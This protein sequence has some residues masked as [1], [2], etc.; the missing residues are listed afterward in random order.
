MSK[1]P[2]DLLQLSLFLFLFHG[3]VVFVESA[4]VVVDDD[5]NVVVDDGTD[6]LIDAVAAAVH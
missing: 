5:R 3:C 1:T 4:V 2:L 6:V